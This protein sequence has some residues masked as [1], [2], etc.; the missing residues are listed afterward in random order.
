VGEFERSDAT[1]Q[2]T[3]LEPGNCY[4]IRAVATNQA[5]NSSYSDLIQVQTIPKG[6]H[7][8]S[9]LLSADS[10]HAKRGPQP[11]RVSQPLPGPDTNT[12]VASEER[13]RDRNDALNETI[14]QLTNHLEAL[15]RQNEEAET[16]LAEEI[17]EAESAKAELLK[18]REELRK[19][20]EEGEKACHEFRKQVL[21]LEKQCKAAQRKKSAKERVLHQKKAERQKMK[22]EIA[23]W[24]TETSEAYQ[25]AEQ[26]RTQKT[27][28]EAE[29]ADQMDAV[30]KQIGEKQVECANMEEELRELGIKVKDLDEQRAK[31]NEEKYAAEAEAEKRR[32][33]EE[34]K[35]ET[36]IQ[37]LQAQ[38]SAW[39]KMITQLEVSR[40][41]EL[42]RVNN[43]L[44][45]K[46]M[47]PHLFTS[48][49]GLDYPM[50][51][52]FPTTRRLRPN[53][54][55]SGALSGVTHSYSGGY[56]NHSTFDSTSSISP[57]FGSVYP[58]YSMGGVSPDIEHLGMTQADVD[59]L[60]AG[61][62]MSPTA[63]T[64]L[65]SDLLMGD[66]DEPISRFARSTSMKKEDSNSRTQPFRPSSTDPKWDDPQSPMSVHST[67]PSIL[68]SPRESL[69][70]MHSSIYGRERQRDDDE[71]SLPPRSS[72][73]SMLPTSGAGS[74]RKISGLFG[75]N[76]REKA[77]MNEPPLL[78]TL[79]QGQ[80][81][82]FPLQADEEDG[83][84][85]HARRKLSANIWGSAVSGLWNRGGTGAQHDRHD[86]L[87]GR[88]G[89]FGNR[90]EPSEVLGETSSRPSSIYS[91]GETQGPLEYPQYGF[92]TPDSTRPRKAA[93][94]WVP[95]NN[96][97]WSHAHSRRA[98]IQYGSTS[99]LSL[100]STP[101]GPRDD[102]ALS[103]PGRRANKP[104]PIGTERFKISQRSNTPKLN[105]AAPSFT[106]RIF[107][108]GESK[109][110]PKA[111][112]SFE[113]GVEKSKAQVVEKSRDFDV[114][115]KSSSPAISRK[116]QDAFSVT[117][118]E[119]LG[120]SHDSLEAY[121]S[122]TTSDMT[123]SVGT[124]K[125]T[126]MQRLTRKSSSTK[127]W[128]KDR[129]GKPPSKG[130]P[131]TPGEVDEEGLD[132][133]GRSMESSS[134]TPQDKRGSLSWSRVMGKTKKKGEPAPSE[135]SE[136][137]SEAEADDD[138]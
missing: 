21:E 31:A 128:G 7:R 82:S 36:H 43:L 6:G 63:N 138:E 94:D 69:S 77:S 85:P 62:P 124:P 78:G 119:S 98:S 58:H 118:A 59:S 56:S 74:S 81:Q 44:R 16:Q 117:T 125:E 4:G 66:D 100:G 13:E 53:A 126:L 65:P 97:P 87:K 47:N 83:F 112:K 133:L 136:R 79:K 123:P 46:D 38:Y 27:T 76:K 135:T 48:V 110:T 49:P 80:S 130:A 101:L 3:G 40:D 106:A 131:S 1:I 89:V 15:K 90:L 30:Q 61:A 35:A 102:D 9:K 103:L 19:S 12:S 92:G 108:R 22:D 122:A 29:H 54:P 17:T 93:T 28:L 5:G 75:W 67:S 57:S 14:S 134:S 8:A 2:V 45:H 51:P 20:A 113:F 116:S 70:N 73:F 104:A 33:A 107:T 88:R 91:F 41:F 25:S 11:R 39:W 129:G 18:K 60:T 109:K 137:A 71:R 37:E 115:S 114:I 10:A 24:E 64:L 26:W 42:D 111:E 55:R 72:P 121:N 52:M 34:Q 32:E 96:G 105:P 99:N 127:F 120:E 132:Y 86:L 68:S 23:R 50:A 95:P 84:N